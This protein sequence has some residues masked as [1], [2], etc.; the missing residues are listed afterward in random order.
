M[1]A[2]SAPALD[3]FV[4]LCG[5]LTSEHDGERATAARMASDLLRQHRLTWAE[6][7]TPAPAQARLCPTCAARSVAPRRAAR[8][9]W[10][11]T[12]AS[13]AELAVR[14]P[15][16]FIDWERAFICNLLDRRTLSERQREILAELAEK[17]GMAC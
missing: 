2:L 15:T 9:S 13:L 8:R 1:P 4:K 16:L 6:V 12:L 3:R 17:A 14:R 7:L 5:L 10:R 11:Q